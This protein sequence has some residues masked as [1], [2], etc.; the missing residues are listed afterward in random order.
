MIPH[1][2][3]RLQWPITSRKT[4]PQRETLLRTLLASDSAFPLVVHL[5]IEDGVRFGTT[6]SGLVR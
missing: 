2:L 4:I 6:F 5:S 1:H 3:Q